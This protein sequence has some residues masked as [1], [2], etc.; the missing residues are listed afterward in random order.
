MTKW[1]DEDPREVFFLEMTDRSDIGVDLNAPQ[2]GHNDKPHHSYSLVPLVHP[3]H[4]V[5]HY[6]KNERAIA[7][8]SRV[9]GLP[10]A[11]QVVWGARGMRARRA[12]EQPFERLGWRVPLDGPFAIEEPVTLGDMRERRSEI[13]A[14]F[15]RLG[16]R[17]GRA[18]MHTPFERSSKRPLRMV[19]VYLAK[20]P[21]EF[22]M[23]FPPLVAILE[24]VESQRFS[25]TIRPKP[26]R[27]A[28]RGSAYRPADETSRKVEREPFTVDPEVI[29]RGTRAHAETQNR[30]ADWLELHGL[31]PLSPSGSDPQYD[32]AAHISGGMFIAEVKSLTELNEERQLR[33]GLGQLL[34]YVHLMSSGGA[35]IVPALVVERQP[36]DGSWIELCESLEVQ[37]TWP[38]EF[39]GLARRLGV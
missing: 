14:V 25:S 26:R 35:R 39:P 34:R 9:I 3:P 19:E 20:L 18:S 11:D 7:S 38:P 24:E 4:V 37:L 15:D 30:L 23:L 29:D 32:A 16:G 1:W 10:Y 27:P 12:G 2:L 13:E 36:L 22:L 8:W 17:I 28:S 31:Q 6:D 21:L 33:L 5:L